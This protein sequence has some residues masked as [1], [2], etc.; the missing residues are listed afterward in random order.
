MWLHW[1]L[2]SPSCHGCGGER[3]AATKGFSSCSPP[4]TPFTCSAGGSQVST[5]LL[6]PHSHC[7]PLFHRQ[8]LS[9]PVCFSGLASCPVHS[10]VSPS[11]FVLSPVCFCRLLGSLVPEGE[12]LLFLFCFMVAAGS[13]QKPVSCLQ[14]RADG[15]VSA[16]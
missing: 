3:A 15:L 2:H 5:R 10:A 4:Q 13:S 9:L 8:L 12:C 7:T 1:M 16:M 14:H 11:L 6:G